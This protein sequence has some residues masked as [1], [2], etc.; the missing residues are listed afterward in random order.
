MAVFINVM[1]MHECTHADLLKLSV[2]SIPKDLKTYLYNNNNDRIYANISYKIHFYLGKY[3]G[4]KRHPCE[5]GEPT[6]DHSGG[7]HGKACWLITHTPWQNHPYQGNKTTE[8][9]AHFFIFP[10]KILSVP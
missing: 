1:L 5:K 6:L 10:V 3:F 9:I 4:G 2:I 7:M 8:H